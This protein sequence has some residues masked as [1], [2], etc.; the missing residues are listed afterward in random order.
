MIFFHLQVFSHDCR[1]LL[2]NLKMQE[3]TAAMT[4]HMESSEV[5]IE[6]HNAVLEW[7][8]SHP[9]PAGRKSSLSASN[10]Q[11]VCVRLRPC[12]KDEAS[13]IGKR[14]RKRA[15][16]DEEYEATQPATHPSK[17]H[18]SRVFLT[19]CIVANRQYRHSRMA[20]TSM[21]QRSR[22]HSILLISC[23]SPIN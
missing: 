15:E 4:D 12:I 18:T 8:A 1:F 3:R 19:L 17:G 5:A 11:V 22:L 13:M 23:H 16:G 21:S 10:N 2:L 20:F 6:L 7:R 9:A 14:S